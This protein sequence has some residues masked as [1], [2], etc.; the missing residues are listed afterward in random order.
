M[1]NTYED[2]RLAIE[3]NNKPL[4]ASLLDQGLQMSP[5]HLS[6]ATQNK[7]YDIL[8]LYLSRGLDI[9][10]DLNDTI[11]S[12][13]VYTFEDT[14]L[15]TWFLA[16]G[17]D[18][19]KKCRLRNCTPLSYAV[20]DGPFE[21]VK[22]LFER[23]GQAQM[24]QLLHYA[25]M[26]CRDDHDDDSREVLQFIYNQDPEYN[27]LQVNKLLDEGTPEYLRNERTGLGSPL[28]YAAMS[29]SA[30]MVAFLLGKGADPGILDLYRR[31]AISYAIRSGH[32]GVA[33]TLK[34]GLVG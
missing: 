11:P 23:G 27:S 30:G 15:L 14:P 22:L 6:I 24:G 7:D 3:S 2:L 16:H 10:A 19:N 8:E 4:T 17:A 31:T 1:E 20:R 32:Y 13:L 29:G 18:P 12:A 26:R 34:G 25:A 33:E 5:Y 9:N 28:H 21:S